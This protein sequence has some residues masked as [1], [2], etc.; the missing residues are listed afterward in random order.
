MARELAKDL[1]DGSDV[2]Y[3]PTT[4]EK[5]AMAAGGHWLEFREE[6]SHAVGQLVAGDALRVR[7]CKRLRE[8]SY[9]WMMSSY[10]QDAAEYPA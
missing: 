3:L 7:S 9:S 2:L 10:G 1:E 8:L 6:H 5:R 4:R